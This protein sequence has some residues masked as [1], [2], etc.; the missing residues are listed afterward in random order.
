MR[1]HSLVG[2]EWE[3]IDFAFVHPN[4]TIGTHCRS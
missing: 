3:S 4:E 2:L 1:V